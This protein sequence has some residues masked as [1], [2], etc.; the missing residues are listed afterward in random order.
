M[1]RFVIGVSALLGFD[2]P[3]Q[4]QPKGDALPEG[5]VARLGE[6]RYGHVGRVFSI[7][8]SPDGKTLLAGAWDGSIR[9]WDVATGKEVRQYAGHTGWVRSVA[10][11]PDG[12]TFASGGKDKII[13]IW[14]TATGKE[15]RRFEGH[16]NWIQ[17]LTFSPDGKRLAS[18]SMEGRT[19]RLWD[20]VT[21]REARR[22]NRPSGITAHVFSP[23][24]KFLAYCDVNGIVL[25]DLAAGKEVWQF[26]DPNSWFVDLA[27]APDGKTLSG[28]RHFAIYRWDTATGKAL[29]P[30]DMRE[31]GLG[32]IVFAP[33]GRSMA[34]TGGDHSI[35]IQE[36]LTRQERC[37]FRSLDN[38]PW[39][40]AYS[41][42]GRLLAQGS[43]D[44]TVV[45]WDAAGL[46][47]K[48]RPR[49]T[50]LAPKELQTL[51]ADLA[52][53]KADVAYQAIGKLA[54]GQK[55]SVPFIQ[56]QLRPVA[57]ADARTV[58]R[59]VADLDSDRFETREQAT[60]QLEKLAELAEPALREAL[61]DKPPLERRQRIDRL[62]ERIAVQRDHPT[63]E[64]LRMLRALEAVEHM[65]T[66]VAR[67]A[68]EEWTKGAPAA[69][70]TIEVNTVLKRLAK[71]ISP[72]RRQGP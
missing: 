27:F 48:G 63:S 14:E 28:F 47:A 2:L 65:D 7:A 24:S 44:I 10:F 31:G 37:R 64:R 19:L 17:N 18:R 9:L 49:P 54:A 60:E 25:F 3:V 51:W 11:A 34:S 61:R 35:R 72:S 41:P 8:F 4:A 6:V 45:L 53:D 38:K 23:D 50:E 59:F 12:K 55:D 71:R 66:P 1:S 32:S 68:L 57:P 33:D 58:A 20:V 30:V 46:R 26:T 43:D 29:R 56:K 52:S 70:L 69:D 16:R 22:I 13:R 21:G 15:L 5:A 36:V 42:D 39:T 62:L 67:R 40:L